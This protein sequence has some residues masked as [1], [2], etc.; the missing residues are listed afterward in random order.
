MDSFQILS[1]QTLSSHLSQ[2]SNPKPF[3]LQLNLLPQMAPKV[4]AVKK[5]PKEA[6]VTRQDEV[7][8][9]FSLNWDKLVQSNIPWHDEAINTITAA[10]L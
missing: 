8:P 1:T 5:S 9:G 6:I 3:F 4:R 2:T 10:G 7:H